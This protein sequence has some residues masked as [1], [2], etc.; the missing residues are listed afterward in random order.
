MTIAF[1]LNAYNLDMQQEL[2]LSLDQLEAAE[3]GTALG[4]IPAA[5]A[6]AAYGYTRGG[7][8]SVFNTVVFALFG[9]S[10][11]LASTLFFAFDAVFI[12]ETP[13]KR[14]AVEKFRE[15]AEKRRLAVAASE[16]KERL[17]RVR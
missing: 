13:A 5:L 11:P 7:Q 3:E 2:P 9:Y 17:A 8:H 4:N 16:K 6:S 1:D 10:Y 12:Q 15:A 14:Y